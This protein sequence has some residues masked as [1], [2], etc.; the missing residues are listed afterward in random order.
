MAEISWTSTLS[1]LWRVLSYD[2]VFK[3]NYGDISS[4]K[5]P[6]DDK[7]VQKDITNFFA[8]IFSVFQSMSQYT[9]DGRVNPQLTGRGSGYKSRIE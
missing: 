3:L 1:E 6:F 9:Y 2:Y 5:P 4:L 8:N 7:T